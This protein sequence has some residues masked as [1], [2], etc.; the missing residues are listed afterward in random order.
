MA[1]NA[2]L[3][4]KCQRAWHEVLTVTSADGALYAQAPRLAVGPKR[5]QWTPASWQVAH[6]NRARRCGC[7]CGQSW[8]IADGDV[9]RW[10]DAGYTEVIPPAAR[11]GRIGPVRLGANKQ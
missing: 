6:G 10:I 2:V 11:I 1:E 4:V 5:S 3:T 8:L 7:A 9:R